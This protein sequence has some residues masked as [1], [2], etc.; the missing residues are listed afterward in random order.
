MAD[1]KAALKKIEHRFRDRNFIIVPINRFLM[2]GDL[3]D[4][5]PLMNECHT[6]KKVRYEWDRK[7]FRKSD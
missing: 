1:I 7:R 5:H 4:F 3:E 6:N 2:K